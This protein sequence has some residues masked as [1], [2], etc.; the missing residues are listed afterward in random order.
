M[1]LE[2]ALQKI[3][4]LTNDPY[5]TDHSIDDDSLDLE[6]ELNDNSNDNSN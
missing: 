5:Y 3:E 2:E 6:G 4:E 1:E